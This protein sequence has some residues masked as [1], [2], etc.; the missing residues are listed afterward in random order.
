M[1]LSVSER[2]FTQEV[3]ESPIPVLVNF[4]APWCGLCLNIQPIL[5]QFESNCNKQIKLVG[6]NADEN[7]LLA[8]S[9]RLKT[10]PTLILFEKGQPRERFDS[11]CGR[12]E[13][14][15][16][17]ENIRLNYSANYQAQTTPTANLESRSAQVA[18]P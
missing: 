12:D 16:K 8:N 7:F 11:F 6:V 14:R 2:T 10:L 5:L 15:L 13:L 18:V 17:L 1:V 4:W 9:Y 3:S